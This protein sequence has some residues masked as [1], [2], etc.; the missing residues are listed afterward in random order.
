MKPIII[1]HGTAGLGKTT[2]ANELLKRYNFDHKL[3][4]G[5][6]REILRSQTTKEEHPYLFINTFRAEDVIENY[7]KQAKKVEEAILACIDRAKREGQSLI[8][9]GNHAFP[10]TFHNIEGVSYV[11]LT[12]SDEEEHYRR[13]NGP[14]HSI[15][16][17][18]RDD[19]K[20][21]REINNHILEEARRFNVTIIENKNM[22]ET[23]RKIDQ[24]LEK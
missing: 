11:V 15:R 9:E 12:L 2:L 20:K 22:E 18:T 6:I 14:T 10:E 8:I 3:G 13:I 16:H 24:I 7:S 17:V 19:F 4:S 21:V 5:W 1:I 23:L